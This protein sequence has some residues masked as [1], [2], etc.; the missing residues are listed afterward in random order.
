[1][2]YDAIIYSSLVG[3]LSVDSDELVDDRNSVSEWMP[4]K[5]LIHHDSWLERHLSLRVF[6][7]IVDLSKVIRRRQELFNGDWGGDS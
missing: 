2:I 1:M 4:G 3:N 6:H 5:V 7:K